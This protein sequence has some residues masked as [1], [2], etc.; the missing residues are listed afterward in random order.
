MANDMK[1]TLVVLEVEERVSAKSGNKYRVAQCYVK[2]EKI[3]VGELM[4]PRDLPCTP[5]EYEAQFRVGRDFDKRICGVLVG[6]H[7]VQAAKAKAA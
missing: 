7:P 3:E 6:L 2:G 1:E 5:G 4:V